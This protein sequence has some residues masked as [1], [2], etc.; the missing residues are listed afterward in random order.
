MSISGVALLIDIKEDMNIIIKSKA[1]ATAQLREIFFTKRTEIKKPT[2][3]VMRNDDDKGAYFRRIEREGLFLVFRLAPVTFDLVTAFLTDFL[4]ARFLMPV[5]R[6]ADCF[7]L[8]RVVFRLPAM[9]LNS[10]FLF[11]YFSQGVGLYS[12]IAKKHK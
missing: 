2:I 11:L 10:S 9:L 3:L 12:L 4:L 7:G 6:L 1:K 8:F 5:F